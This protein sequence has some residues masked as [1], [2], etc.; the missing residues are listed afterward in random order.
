MAGGTPYFGLGTTLGKYRITMSVLAPVVTMPS[1][2]FPV[3]ILLLLGLSCVQGAPVYTVGSSFGNVV[4]TLPEA[5]STV[6]A[7]SG[8]VRVRTSSPA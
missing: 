7:G 4:C 2:E 6:N 1:V 3:L 8:L 5:I